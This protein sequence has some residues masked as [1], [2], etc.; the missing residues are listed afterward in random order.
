MSV[1]FTSHLGISSELLEVPLRVSTPVGDSSVV[2][3]VYRS[4]VVTIQGL[5]TQVDLIFL[6]LLDFDVILGMDWL[7]PRHAV[8][9]CYA[10]TVNLGVPGIPP[11]LW[12]GSYSRSPT[13]IISFMRARRL[14]TSGC[15]AYLAYV[16]DVSAEP[17]SV[18]SVPIVREFSDVFPT[19]LP[20][21]PPERDI[22]FAIDLEPG[23][24]PISIPPY[25]IAPAELR[26]LSV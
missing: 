11:V 3:Q 23:S 9:D 4:C 17:H 8:L 13:G 24:K 5:D 15:L 1:Y 14:V 16:R 10:K 25:C 20:G 26:E 6:Y 2:D 19:D 21:L 12:Q 18:D 22:D 7:S